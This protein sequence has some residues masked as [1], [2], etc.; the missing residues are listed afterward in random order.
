VGFPVQAG[1]AAFFGWD[2]AQAAV[3]VIHPA[4]IAADKGFGAALALG[5]FDAA[6]AA[7]IAKGAN[8]AVLA[9][10]GD[11]GHTGCQAGHV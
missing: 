9:P 8:D 11:N 10:H 1:E 4:V 3:E 2:M 6:M 7:G 5:Q